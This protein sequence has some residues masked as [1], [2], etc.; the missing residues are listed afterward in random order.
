MEDHYALNLLFDA[1]QQSRRCAR[2]RTDADTSAMARRVKAGTVTRPYRGMYARTDYWNALDRH[3]QVRHVVRTL[4]SMHP[5][6]VFCGPT[7]AIMHGL[8]CSYRLTGPICIVSDRP[9]RRQSSKQLIRYAITY[10]DTEMADGV[11]VTGLLRTLYDCVAKLPT[12]YS[13]AQLDSA[14]RLG[15]VAAPTLKAYPCSLPHVR[16]R[17][18][19]EEVFDLADGRSENGGESEGRGVL[20]TIGYPPDDIQVEFPCL[21]RQRRVH[22]VDYLWKREDGSLLI[23]EFD[24]VRKYID[25][26]MTSGRTIRAVVDDER[27]RQRCLEHQGAAII[28]FYYTDL[29]YPGRIARGLSAQGLS[30]KS[31]IPSL[32]FPYTVSSRNRS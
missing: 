7:A 12:R 17:N 8:D 23:G 14:I 13:L 20:A 6:W 30:R 27:D 11:P 18:R 22:R 16:D 1:A 10:P 29:D 32:P 3:E 26:T 2:P 9:T 5:D 19:I 21:Q 15:K 28:R 31:G 4:S 24:G 25:P